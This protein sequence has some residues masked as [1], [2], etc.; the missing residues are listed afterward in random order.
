MRRLLDK[1]AGA[2]LLLTG[3]GAAANARREVDRVSESVTK[4]DAQLDRVND[5]VP[6]RAA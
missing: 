2:V 3:S 5:P 6:P 1:L 4:I